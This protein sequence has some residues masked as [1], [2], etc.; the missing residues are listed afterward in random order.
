MNMEVEFETCPVGGHNV[1]GKVERKIR[2][3]R[4]SIEKTMHNERLSILQWETLAAQ[5]S[6]SINDLAI[7]PTSS[8]AEL[9]YADLITPNRLKLGRNNDRSP[10]GVLQVT[11]DPSRIFHANKL[12]CNTWFESWLI[13]YVPKLINHP[14]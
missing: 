7:A 9:E 4:E 5:V 13:S 10:S 1:H 14:K 11:S 12:I 3:I 6:N 2:T 8:V